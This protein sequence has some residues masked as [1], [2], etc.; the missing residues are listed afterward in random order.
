MN[1]FLKEII[2]TYFHQA[3]CYQPADSLMH[4][5]GIAINTSAPAKVNKTLP[6]IMSLP[7]LLL[8]RTM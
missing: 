6:K 2:A 3:S 8:L 5:L 4:S 7:P 1:T